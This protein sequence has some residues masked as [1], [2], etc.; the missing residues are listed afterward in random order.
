M[1]ICSFVFVGI[2]V[3]T[4]ERKVYKIL[5]VSI[6]VLIPLLSV[7]NIYSFINDYM[8]FDVF[9]KELLTE[10]TPDGNYYWHDF[11]NLQVENKHWVG[12]YIC[13]K[14]LKEEWDKRSDFKFDEVDKKGQRIKYT[15][16]RYLTS[17]G[18]RKDGESVRSLHQNDIDLI[19]AGYAN[20]IFKDKNKLYTRLYQVIWEVDLYLRGG[21]PSG[22]SVAQ[23]IEYLRASSTIISNNPFFGVGT[24]D[25]QLEF[26]KQYDIM[27]SKLNKYSRHRAHNQFVTFIITFGFLGALVILFALFYPPFVE[28]KYSDFLFIA[29]LL[30][31]VVSMLNE[32]TLETQPGVTFFAFFYSLFIFGRRKL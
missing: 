6:S 1:L 21:N 28:R 11:N 13:N 5:L 3:R 24:G 9:E 29:F 22:H 30:V 17:K 31:A 25:V 15:I 26:N 27:E 8:K 18:L 16:I 14:E 12:L 7:L 20:W 19:E 4:I 32:D 10:T 2:W 23:R